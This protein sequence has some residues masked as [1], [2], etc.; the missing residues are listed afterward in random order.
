MRLR[1][2]RLPTRTSGK[3]WQMRH[4]S[5]CGRERLPRS[6]S[7]RRSKYWIEK[8]SSAQFSM[9]PRSRTRNTMVTT[10]ALPRRPRA[11]PIAVRRIESDQA[12]PRLYS[13]THLRTVL[14]RGVAGLRLVLVGHCHPAGDG[15]DSGAGDRA[16]RLVEGLR[17]RRDF[18]IAVTGWGGALGVEPSREEMAELLVNSAQKGHIDRVIVA[19]ADRRGSLPVEELLQLRLGG[20]K[21]EDA[22][23]L[24][25]KIYG[26]I[27]LD[28][29]MPSWLIF[30]E[31]FW[32]N[33]ASQLMRRAISILISLTGL[34]LALPLLPLIALA[35]K[36]S[37]PGE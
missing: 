2:C 34:L 37:S 22:T 23:T 25:E 4:C 11:R 33:P 3:R 16:K 32:L 12:V 28:Q 30:S 6:S 17:K 19:M 8:R 24:L 18:G 36:L 29:L 10:I 14:G 9:K 27:E 13:S 31:G 35:V 1:W 15:H 26:K 21:I 7:K 20:V 5:S